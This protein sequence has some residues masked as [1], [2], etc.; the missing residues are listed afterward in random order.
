[1]AKFSDEEITLEHKTPLVALPDF[2]HHFSRCC[3]WAINA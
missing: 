2:A 1:V 3:E